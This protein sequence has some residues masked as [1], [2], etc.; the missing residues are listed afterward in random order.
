MKHIPGNVKNDLKMNIIHLRGDL[1]VPTLRRG[2]AILL[3]LLL[4]III[5]YY[6]YVNEMTIKRYWVP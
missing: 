5:I 1:G 2:D 4:I 3:L 6:L